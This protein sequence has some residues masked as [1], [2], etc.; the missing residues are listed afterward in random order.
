MNCRVFKVNFI[1]KL[2]EKLKLANSTI[3]K[4]CSMCRF[5]V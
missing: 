4:L 3:F 2:F 1:E 5:V